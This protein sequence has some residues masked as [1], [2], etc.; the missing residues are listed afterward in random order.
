MELL[1]QYKN[2]QQEFYAQVAEKALKLDKLPILQE[3]NYRICVLE[4]LQQFCKT[5]PIT[6]DEKALGY[7][8]HLVKA[9]IK[10]LLNER[11]FGT[12]TDE[13]G[14]AQRETATITLQNVVEDVFAHFQN[15][16]KPEDYKK[17]ICGVINAVLSVWMPYR[18]TY[19]KI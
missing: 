1:V 8:F 15:P 13:R 2:K 7:H 4:T 5:A 12:I 10:A 9:A 19:V 14:K 3:L 6:L 18:D 11:K 16:T 17:S